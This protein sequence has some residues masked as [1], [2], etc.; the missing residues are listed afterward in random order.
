MSLERLKSLFVDLPQFVLFEFKPNTKVN[1]RMEVET[2][3]DLVV[4]G[5]HESLFIPVDQVLEV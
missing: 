4:P 2:N 3:N 5:S 1:H